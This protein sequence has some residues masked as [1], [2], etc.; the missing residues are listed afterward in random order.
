MLAPRAI[1]AADVPTLNQNTSGNAATA[2]ALAASPTNCSPGAAP[3]GINASGTAQNCTTYV[4]TICTATQALST[5][6]IAPGGVNTT[7]V[8]CTGAQVGDIPNC[9]FTTSV[10]GITGYDVTINSGNVLTVDVPIVQSPNSITVNARSSLLNTW[11]G[12][13]GAI[14]IK[15]SITR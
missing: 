2:S 12:S 8:I 15:C 5:T 7:P 9:K 13:P 10:A 6:S 1:V 4:Q 3:Q 11:T 14:S